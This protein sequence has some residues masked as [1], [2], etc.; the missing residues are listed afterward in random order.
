MEATEEQCAPY[1]PCAP[2]DPVSSC[3][4]V[5]SVA[6]SVDW[7]GCV[8]NEGQRTQRERGAVKGRDLAAKLGALAM[9]VS[10]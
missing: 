2:S 9:V 5:A 1:T 3:L 6:H 7:F 8:M 4:C 10:K